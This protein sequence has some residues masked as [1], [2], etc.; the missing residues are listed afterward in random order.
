MLMKLHRS[1]MKV[2]KIEPEPSYDNPE[3]LYFVDPGN[4]PLM[5]QIIDKDGEVLEI[6]LHDEEKGLFVFR[7][8][9]R[10]ESP[11]VPISIVRKVIE[12]L[13][14]KAKEQHMCKECIDK[15]KSK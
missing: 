4:G 12:R 6:E 10:T 15:E 3:V 11:L 9:Q 5:A 13:E 1:M 2:D 7:A 14:Q 8:F